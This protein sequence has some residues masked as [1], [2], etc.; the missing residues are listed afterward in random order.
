MV[1][2]F[3]RPYDSAYLRYLGVLDDYKK[4]P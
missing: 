3:K 4:Q 2:E 1:R